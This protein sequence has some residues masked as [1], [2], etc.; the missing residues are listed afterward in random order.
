MLIDSH[1]HLQDKAFK[2]DFGEVLAR[3]RAAG[4]QV[5]ILPGSNLS[6][7]RKALDMH[8]RAPD[9]L[10]AVGIHPHDAAKAADNDFRDIEEMAN[11]EFV[12]AVGEIGLDFHY[13]FSPA[14]IQEQALRRQIQI[15]HRAKKPLI[16]HSRESQQRLLSILREEE[17]DRCGGVVHCFSGNEKEAFALLEMGFTLGFTGIITFKGSQELR[18]IAANVPLD[19]ILVET[20]SPYLAPQPHRGK[21]NEPSYIPLIVKEIAEIRK[22]SVEEIGEV[23]N[24]NARRIFGI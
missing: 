24:A 14:E 8:L 16:L 11:N 23:V 15:A 22:L 18:R 21:R 13:N 2:T 19:R 17:G 3:A 10:P 6:T 20:D 9:L 5:I 12:V 4:V 7:S 1:A